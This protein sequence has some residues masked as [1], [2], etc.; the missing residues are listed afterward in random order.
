MNVEGKK[1]PHSALWIGPEHI[2][3]ESCLLRTVWVTGRRAQKHSWGKWER[4][5][6]AAGR[7]VLS[8]NV[9]LLILIDSSG[10]LKLKAFFP[11]SSSSPMP[12]LCSHI[13][14]SCKRFAA[15]RKHCLL[16]T[17]LVAVQCSFFCLLFPGEMAFSISFAK[18]SGSKTQTCSTCCNSHRLPPVHQKMSVNSP[19]QAQYIGSLI[20]AVFLLLRGL[21]CSVTAPCWTAVTLHPRHS[22]I[23]LT[24]FKIPVLANQQSLLGGKNPN[25]TQHY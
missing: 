10:G 1:Q 16:P 20:W 19:E 9:S 24:S 17:Q 18:N 5:Q 25:I 2:P 22:C 7:T 6:R 11:F 12:L 15:Y 14:D 3:V 23:S 8:H 21:R 13:G 4:M